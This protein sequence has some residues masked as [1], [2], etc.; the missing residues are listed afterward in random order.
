[1]KTRF[2]LT[3]LARTMMLALLCIVW[4]S[5]QTWAEDW[6]IMGDSPFSWTVGQQTQNQ[7]SEIGVDNK[8]RIIKTTT[9]TG[10]TWI[11][12]ILTS[13][14]S[15]NWD[16][17]NSARYGSENNSGINVYD[18]SWTQTYQGNNGGNIWTE[19]NSGSFIWTWN[20]TTKKIR[21]DKNP[22]TLYLLGK[23]ASKSTT[24][25]PT[26][27][28]LMSTSDG[29]TYSITNLVLAA[30]DEFG[31][32]L[33][34]GS[35]VDDWSTANAKRFGPT[36]TKALTTGTEQL[37]DFDSENKYTV[38]ATEAGTYDITV[39]I[40]TCKATIT[41][42]AVDA[43]TYTLNIYEP[44]GTPYVNGNE[45]TATT[46]GTNVTWY[47]YTY[48]GATLPSS[49]TLADHNQQV[50]A[51]ITPVDGATDY[52]YFPKYGQR[53]WTATDATYTAPTTIYIAGSFQG[54]SLTEM[55]STDGNVFT[56]TSAAF[57]NNAVTD[58]RFI[59][60]T[61]ATDWNQCYRPTTN[62]EVVTPGQTVTT[63]NQTG[64]D[65]S[66]SIPKG[67]YT[68]T[69]TLSTHSFVVSGNPDAVPFYLHATDASGN[70]SNLST[71]SGTFTTTDG[72]N[73]TLSNVALT[74]GAYF[75]FSTAVGDWNAINASRFDAGSGSNIE[76]TSGTEYT[77]TKGNGGTKSYII[78]TGGNWSFTY[79]II[80]NVW[81]ATRA[82]AQDETEYTIY[83]IDKHA[84][85]P[86]LYAWD[87]YGNQLHG[88]TF[89]GNQM[90]TTE[91]I[92]GE[93]WYKA[94]IT[95]EE[96]TVIASLGSSATQTA[97]IT[98]TGTPYYIVIDGNQTEQADR[99]VYSSTTAPT[100]QVQDRNTFTVYARSTDG[101]ELHAYVYG[102]CGE[103]NGSWETAIA[104]PLAT[105]TLADGLIWYKY[106]L[107]TLADKYN[108]IFYNSTASKQ[109]VNITDITDETRYIVVLHDDLDND[110]YN[111]TYTTLPPTDKMYVI[112]QAGGNPW[113]TTSGLE[114]TKDTDGKFKLENVQIV[115]GAKFAFAAAL[116]GEDDW[117]TFNKR[118]ITSAASAGTDF[119][120]SDNYTDKDNPVEL[121]LRLHDGNN[122]RN[123]RANETAY[124]DITLNPVTMKATITRKYG[125]LYMYYGDENSAYWSPNNGVPMI[126]TDG[127]TFTL[128]GV[129]LKDG[130]TFQFSSHL[131][132][133][134]AA[135]GGWDEIDAYRY[136]SNAEK[137]DWMVKTEYINKTLNALV[138]GTTN[139]KMD[140]G[141]AGN[142]RVIVTLPANDQTP[143][144][145]TLKK[146]AE[147]L[148]GT[149]T[150]H[151]EQSSN[152]TNPVLWAYDKETWPEGIRIHVDRPSR[153]TIAMRRAIP[154][155]TQLADTTT[156]D[157]RK[158]WT[159][160]VDNSIVDFWFTRGGYDPRTLNGETVTAYA[161]ENKDMTDIQWRK[162][163]EIFLTWDGGE[164]TTSMSDYTRDY[165]AA[166]A[167]EAADCAVMIE[168]HYYAYFTNT[169]GWS[170][171]FCHAWY[172][173]SEGVNQDLLTP[174]GGTTPVYPGAQCELVGYD[175]DGYAVYR[176]DLTAATGGLI[177]EDNKPVGIIFNNGIDN[178]KDPNSGD[179]VDWDYGT[180][181]ATTTSKEQTGDFV[182]SNGACYDY[183]GIIV[184]GRSLGNIIKN[185]VVDG[186]VYTVED[187]LVGVWVDDEEV[188][189]VTVDG[190]E[191][192]FYGALYCKDLNQ[193][194][195]T[196]YVEKSLQKEGEI[197][198]M[199][200]LSDLSKFMDYRTRYDQSNWVKLVFS[201]QYPDYKTTYKDNQTNQVNALLACQGKLLKGGSVK[202]Q[203][204]NNKNPE[205]RLAQQA[206][207]TNAT[208]NTY[209]PNVFITSNF[210]GTQVS[211][212][213]PKNTYFFVTPKPQE[214]AT[215]YWAVWDADSETFFVPV[216]SYDNSTQRWLNEA[217]LDGG[218]KIDLSLNRDKKVTLTKLNDGDMYDNFHAIIRLAD[219]EQTPTQSTTG[220]APRRAHSAY[221]SPKTESE[222]TSKYIVY[223]IDLT[224]DN[225]VTGVT[226]ANIGGKTVESVR[227]TNL[228]GMQSDKPFDGL[229]I[230]VTTYTDGTQQVV[231][232]MR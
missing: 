20:A 26:Q 100:E 164:N 232:Q 123:F 211:P 88:N 205:I 68:I 218:F 110:R 137:G 25:N 49:I 45:V 63:N 39:N 188:T 157:G 226:D 33:T 224:N 131:A 36:S 4:A 212:L 107:N 201:T 180:G 175:K 117:A 90:T 214:Y 105:E 72:I 17:I 43:K 174:P 71:G 61:S 143:G 89:P 168:G 153:D 154:N 116:A 169:P 203:L 79:N 76:I 13:S 130:D 91:T 172:T 194:T 196:A 132:T 145:V 55:P 96:L 23:I 162:A 217:D 1:M 124:Y 147:V 195:S 129:S 192:T 30:D 148:S 2:S 119:Y 54:W 197:D 87:N 133:K 160:K 42:Q 206:L 138:A 144:T 112:G 82:A 171:V 12:F 182:Y 106:T 99:L 15:S 21:I 75:L 198:Y 62:G 97:D 207:P 170:Q 40:L 176:I 114:M 74:Q 165:Y 220:N 156:A 27:G 126:T 120:L 210:L 135:S 53:T 5:P 51:T 65:Y 113:S 159:Y 136:G 149:T 6:Y 231:K 204:V 222:V 67:T 221:L 223:P 152:V 108:L 77:A 7:L 85:T 216:C 11:N 66:W 111:V 177:T 150:I 41:K 139:F 8:Y 161:L 47:T 141:T 101:G 19:L 163:G 58:N 52:Y 193:F 37:T 115:A 225:V 118:R 56:Y 202:G 102:D 32:T 173:D 186:P 229:N 16:D 134:D 94:T 64:G 209:I 184:L 93:T 73:Y 208:D 46:Q 80:T 59:F 38:S 228:A 10:S 98:V 185:G 103:A 83:V 155:V 84:N 3:K 158:W 166:A 179:Y 187:D 57:A 81:T 191:H 183:C 181:A 190:V 78:P 200:S 151:L 189:T 121:A 44:F 122:D 230:I 28:T 9:Y 31:F 167:Q 14:S 18:A 92:N 125:A 22:G 29:I 140:E 104:A 178:I 86:Y 48:S 24:W 219:S 199:A 95:A 146:M 35:S 215:I 142:Y 213:Y 60:G 69:Y 34:L 70:W 127:E 227:Y 109:T 50:T 128:S